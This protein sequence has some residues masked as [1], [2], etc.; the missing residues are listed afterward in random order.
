[1]TNESNKKDAKRNM[2]EKQSQ[3]EDTNVRK[4]Q[5][6]KYSSLKIESNYKILFDEIIHK[7]RITQVDFLE[8]LLDEWCKNFDEEIYED[9][10]KGNLPNQK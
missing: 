6:K 4:K 7:R 9:F 2:L 5:L 10:K 1:M 3:Q 8:K